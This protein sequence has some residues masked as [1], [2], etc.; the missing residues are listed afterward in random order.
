MM[1]FESPF[2][3]I[4]FTA[5]SIAAFEIVDSSMYTSGAFLPALTVSMVNWQQVEG[6]AALEAS[7]ING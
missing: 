4:T 7:D 2:R 3:K 5:I 6:K 1:R